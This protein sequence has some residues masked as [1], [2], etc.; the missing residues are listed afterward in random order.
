MSILTKP[1]PDYV[2]ANEKQYRVNTD[3]RV[4]LEFDRVIHLNIPDREKMYRVFKLCYIDEI[5]YNF[6]AAYKA[7]MV[8]YAAKEERDDCSIV[9]SSE[10][11]QSVKSFDFEEDAP[12]IFA[13]FMSEYGIDLTKIDLHWWLFTALLTALGENNKFT[14][15]VSWRGM[16]LSKIKNKEQREMIAKMKR[17][18]KLKDNRSPEEI[19]ADFAEQFWI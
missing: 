1:L 14:K 17:L 15:I 5:P 10:G 7:L 3:Y 2:T 16:N 18:Y 11:K 6:I 13:A 9:P 8:F 4:W 12:Y 19:E